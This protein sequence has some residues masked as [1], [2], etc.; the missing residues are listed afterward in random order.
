MEQTITHI[1]LKKEEDSI[2]VYYVNEA[3]KTEVR[4]TLLPSEMHL[5]RTL[6]KAIIF[7][8]TEHVETLLDSTLVDQTISSEL[9][10]ITSLLLNKQVFKFFETSDEIFFKLRNSKVIGTEAGVEH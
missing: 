2:Q 4:V 5:P 8:Q 1:H 6:S 10:G 7:V 9:D 3:N